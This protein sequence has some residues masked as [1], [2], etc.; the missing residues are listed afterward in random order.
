MDVVPARRVAVARRSP[1]WLDI[2]RETTSRVD[3]VKSSLHDGTPR[4]APPRG[5][6]PPASGVL[7]VCV[8]HLYDFLALLLGE[9]RGFRDVDLDVTVVS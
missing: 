2:K 1:K 6:L 5:D 7:S 8:R 3:G 9:E 4:Y